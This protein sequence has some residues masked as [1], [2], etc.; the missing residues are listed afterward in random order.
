MHACMRGNECTI[1]GDSCNLSFKITHFREISCHQYVSVSHGESLGVRFTCAFCDCVACFEKNH[2]GVV[3]NNHYAELVGV[4]KC[5]VCTGFA[6][7]PTSTWLKKNFAHMAHVVK[8][9]INL[10]RENHE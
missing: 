8:G 2:Y 1:G 4:N 9:I 10:S 6:I 3:L 7:Q 5:S